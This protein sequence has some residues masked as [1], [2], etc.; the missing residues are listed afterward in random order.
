MMIDFFGT[1]PG[2][3]S[4]AGL[5][6]ILILVSVLKRLIARARVR[7]AAAA[8][9]SAPAPT[10]SGFAVSGQASGSA[11]VSGAP[12]AAGPG[13]LPRWVV[14]AIAVWAVAEIGGRQASGFAAPSAAAWG[15]VSSGPD[16]WL[17]AAGPERRNVGVTK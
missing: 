12:A 6:L 16:P 17:A 13:G 10:A 4:L 14:A 2:L 15:P 1:T 9:G 11:G 5:A 7:R 8:A 3:L